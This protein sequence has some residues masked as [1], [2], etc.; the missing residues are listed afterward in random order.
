IARRCLFCT[1]DR[2]AADIMERGHIAGILRDAV[3]LGLDPMTAVT[4]AT[5]N[6][7]ECYGLRDRGAVAPGKRADL[8]LVED[9]KDFRVTDVWSGGARVAGEG[10]LTAPCERTDLA[11]V[12]ASV[13]LA[14]FTEADFAVLA[15]SGRARVIGLEPH[16]LITTELI[17]EVTVEADGRVMLEKNP[18]LLKL[19]V[20]ERHRATGRHG[21]ALL[22]RR[23]GLR[24]GAIATSIAH[25]S[26]NI[27]VAGDSESD[28]A[29]AV[30]AVEA[31]GGGIAMVSSGDVLAS[32]PLPVG[33][34]MSDAAPSEVAA[35]LRDLIALA[36]DHFGIW[37]KAD[38]FMTLS[39]LAL[40][41]IPKLKLTADGLFDAEKFTFVPTD[42]PA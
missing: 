26:H 17:E 3:A 36:R 7:A 2:H 12:A 9:L 22:D 11:E 20:L 40:P 1:D 27:V 21:V 14:P 8:V 30:R 37:E 29:A 28:M 15:P 41:V 16:S 5:L 23:Y 34:L 25:D 32:L 38:A 18:G 4:M 39:F 19:V 33:G 10:S 24:N 31:M 13:R 42:A 35:S 6:A